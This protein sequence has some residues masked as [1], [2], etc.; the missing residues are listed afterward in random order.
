MKQLILIPEGIKS[1]SL[2]VWE[3]D[4]SKPACYR[5]GDQYKFNSELT[6]KFRFK[7]AEALLSKLR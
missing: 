2:L 3:V 5:E 1:I 4:P 6:E 7:D